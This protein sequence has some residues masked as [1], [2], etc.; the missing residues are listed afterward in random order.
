[1]V[2]DLVEADDAIDLE[3]VTGELEQGDVA[4]AEGLQ[5]SGSRSAEDEM[6]WLDADVGQNGLRRQQNSVDGH[7]VVVG[8]ETGRQVEAQVRAEV[9]LATGRHRRV[10]V[11]HEHHPRPKRRIGFRQ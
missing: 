11:Q 5:S 4:L 10:P 3:F 6:R 8:V 1:M 2:D 9:A 7:V